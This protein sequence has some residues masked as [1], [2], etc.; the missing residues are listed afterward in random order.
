VPRR[1]GSVSHGDKDV[2]LVA[3]FEIR[4]GVPSN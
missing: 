3:E 2:E 1:G 4:Y